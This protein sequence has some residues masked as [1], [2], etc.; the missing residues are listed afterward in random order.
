MGEGAGDVAHHVLQTGDP[1]AM[2]GPIVTQRDGV[3]VVDDATAR[4][5]PSVFGCGPEMD[6]WRDGQEVEPRQDGGRFVAD[7]R[8]LGQGQPDGIDTDEIAVL[9]AQPLPPLVGDVPTPPHPAQD[10]ALHQPPH[11]SG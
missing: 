7:H 5:A 9:G 11:S 8:R 4:T 10:P 3:P 6:V 1:D 2:D